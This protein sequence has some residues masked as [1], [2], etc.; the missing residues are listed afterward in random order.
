MNMTTDLRRL[1]QDVT[2]LSDRD[3]RQFSQW[4]CRREEEREYRKVSSGTKGIPHAQLL[5]AF[6]K[7]SHFIWRAN[8]PEIDEASH[9]VSQLAN[10]YEKTRV[11]GCP[12]DEDADML[13]AEWSAASKKEFSFSVI[14]QVTPPRPPDRDTEIWQL[15]IE[16]RLPM[17]PAL[18]R[19][20][21]G[22]KS[23]RSLAQVY[24][25]LDVGY[26][27]RLASAMEDVRPVKT[28]V[29]YENV[30]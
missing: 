2:K 1:K 15:R 21:A 23:C 9:V 20:K 5:E 6:K 18:E 28:A 30:E 27:S 24:D 10:F 11:R 25:W 16:I 22:S 29:S 19:I 7:K 13:I 17:S 14:R 26:N 8:T 12:F 3:L 4:L